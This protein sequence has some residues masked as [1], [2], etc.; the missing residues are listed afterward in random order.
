[1]SAS[2]DMQAGTFLVVYWNFGWS[3]HE[4]PD[5]QGSIRIVKEPGQVPLELAGAKDGAKV[6]RKVVS[7]L[8][9]FTTSDIVALFFS[10]S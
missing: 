7:A 8:R 6:R 3:M 1:M 2:E 4:G 5:N 9:C 10:A